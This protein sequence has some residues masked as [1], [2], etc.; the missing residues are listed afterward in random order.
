MIRMTYKQRLL[1]TTALLRCKRALELD[2]RP[3]NSVMRA[4]GFVYG[5]SIPVSWRGK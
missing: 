2:F 5:P 4:A 3:P 1:N